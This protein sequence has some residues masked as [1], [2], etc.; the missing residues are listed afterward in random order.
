MYQAGRPMANSGTRAEH[1]LGLRVPTQVSLVPVT[2]RTVK[3]RICVKYC[4]IAIVFWAVAIAT[5]DVEPPS[6]IVGMITIKGEVVESAVRC[7]VGVG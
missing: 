2:H 3:I 1:Q 6:D 7:Q 5:I 4:K